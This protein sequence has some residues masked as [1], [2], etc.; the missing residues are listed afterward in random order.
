MEHKIS[1][2][3]FGS[4]GSMISRKILE[5]SLISPSNLYLSN[6]SIDKLNDFKSVFPSINVVDNQTAVKESEIIIICVKPKDF[7]SL[8]KEIQ[9]LLTPQKHIVSIT[10]TIPFSTIEQ[11]HNG[12][13]TIAIPTVTG[14]ISKGV[15][16]FVFNSKIASGQREDILKVFSTMG[17][18][19]EIQPEL[20]DIMVDLTSC[21]PGFIGALFNNYLKVIEN[22]IKDLGF[23]EDL[24]KTLIATAKGTFDLMDDTQMSFDD[25]ISRVATKGGITE[26]GIKI[27]NEKLP[28]IYEQVIRDTLEKRKIMRNSIEI[29]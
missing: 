27:I 19:K 12:P 15:S 7:I 14:E 29:K 5:K 16:L 4:M 3:G 18:V 13:I 25:L 11:Y 6:R 21:T 9:P 1:I 23:N 28:V 2:I 24:E 17:K 22:H 10:A 20:L 26:V 8:L